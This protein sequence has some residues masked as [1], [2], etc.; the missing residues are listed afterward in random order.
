MIVLVNGQSASAAEIVAAAL[1]DRGRAVLV[2]TTSYG[3]GTVQTVVKLANEG[4]L[5]MT[6]SRL[7]AP[8]GY[9]WNELGVLPNVCSATAGDLPLTAL[10]ASDSNRAN[11][12]RWHALRNPTHEEVTT[13]RKIC[14][15][16]Q[17]SP[18]R[19]L[20]IAIRLLGDR[21]LY[22]RAVRAGYDQAALTRQ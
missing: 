21:E 2:G 3:K 4:E 15:P 1:Q 13:L 8:S 9:T 18:D 19:D 7:L 20:D 12:M 10:A 5:I 11:L 22:A 17:D 6:W 14:P 16:G